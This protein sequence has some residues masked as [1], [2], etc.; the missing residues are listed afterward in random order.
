MIEENFSKNN[1]EYSQKEGIIGGTSEEE[2][3][4]NSVEHLW[5]LLNKVK[6][7]DNSNIESI[8]K[9]YWRQNQDKH[10]EFIKIS[11]FGSTFHKTFGRVGGQFK[12]SGY[13]FR[14]N[15]LA[16]RHWYKQDKKIDN[17]YKVEWE[18]SKIAGKVFN[19]ND[20]DISFFNKLLSITT[21][22]QTSII[23][24]GFANF[25]NE[26]TEDFGYMNEVPNNGYDFH[27]WTCDKNLLVKRLT[28]LDKILP[29][30]LK[31]YNTYDFE[32]Y[33]KRYKKEPIIIFEK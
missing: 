28:E 4:Q 10:W 30:G 27:L 1:I 29:V 25:D 12:I 13:E 32:K 22:F 17:T 2:E 7:L 21:C 24:E 15:K 6:E 31:I 33:V 14:D 11:Q 9:I 26:L 20:D 18:F 23:N 16:H 5:D 19:D 3:I 8:T